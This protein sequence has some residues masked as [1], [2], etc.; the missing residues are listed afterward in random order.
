M[1]TVVSS[2]LIA[3]GTVVFC[4][5]GLGLLRLPDV[6]T[7]ISAIGTA[8]G[9]GVAFIVLGVAL[10][11]PTLANAIKA[12]VAILLQVTTSVIGATAIARAA[13]LRRQ[14]FA[15]GTDLDSVAHLGAVASR[16]EGQ[17]PG[18]DR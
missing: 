11:D 15:S 1:L 6:F 5:A 3:V 12:M 18:R 13:V 2:V 7:R 9:I 10:Q 4:I 8:A 17:T 16:P 14:H